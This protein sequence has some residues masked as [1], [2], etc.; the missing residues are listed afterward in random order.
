M[1][2]DV[3]EWRRCE[4]TDPSLI[5]APLQPTP[6][7][8][9]ALV[10]GW[11]IYGALAGLLAVSLPA[12]A[13]DPTAAGFILVIGGIGLWR[14]AWWLTHAVRAVLY[15]YRMFPRLRR[16]ADAAAATAGGRAPKR[17]FVLVTSYRV[18][19]EISFAVYDALVGNVLDLGRPTT[20]VAAITDRTDVDVINHVLAGRGRPDLVE[21]VYS[22]QRGDG[23]RSAMGEVLRA[24]ARRMPGPD[25]LVVFMDGDIRLPV[26]T[27][28]RSIPFFLIEPGLG[29]LTT[30][31]GAIVDGG[32]ATRAWYDLKYAQRHMQMCSVALSGRVLVLT[33]RYSII[34]AP[35]A[36]RPD[37]I[38][39]IERDQL[40]HWRFGT[41]RF[42]SGDD[43]S[44]WFW[45]LRH[46]WTMRYL[47][48]VQVHGF[49]EL[50]MTGRFI[51]ST[52]ELMR[53]W[54]GNML[55][56]SGRAIRL[57]PTRMG[58]F[59]WWC[60]VD[61]RLSIWTTLTGPVVA[62]MVTFLINPAFALAYALWVMVT[63]L[64][65]AAV[66]GWSRGRLSP[67]WP[68]LLFYNQVVGSLTKSA[69]SFD[70]ARQKWVRQGIATGGGDSRR[71]VRLRRES[72][73]MH[74]AALAVLFLLVGLG[75]G[76][77]ALPNRGT[78][79]SLVGTVAVVAP[80]PE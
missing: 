62:V 16:C 41:F 67:F 8:G 3:L 58:W 43:K 66:L 40:V 13:F 7:R 25:D 31:N 26:G 76:A 57:G 32:A 24:I 70:L 68:V 71:M 30:D 72:R 45:L 23:K 63:R 50:P 19:P 46:G 65:A 36:T 11:V 49:E 69:V 29:G 73:V 47:P 74:A 9:P 38:A 61:Q 44:S 22:F 51:A 59:T 33:G 35:L 18:R 54:Y 21:V 80:T 52:R 15:R 17:I 14:Y 27:L 12:S 48:D 4:S 77:L 1:A 53:R 28:R 10:I 20:I 34:R 2:D 55:R 42:L 79:A 75:T 39:Q 64:I 6:D 60:L 5:P 56:N 78:V 37:F